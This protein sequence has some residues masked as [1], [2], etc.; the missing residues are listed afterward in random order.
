MKKRI[1]SLLLAVMMIACLLPA[2]VFAWPGGKDRY[3]HIDVRV[4][5]TLIID[6]KVN[7]VSQPGYPKN[8]KVTV[9]DVSATQ[10]GKDVGKF[11]KKT[12]QGEENEWR[13][14]GLNL[15]LDDTIVINCTISY[16]LNGKNHSQSF[17]KTYTG[18]ALKQA[19]QECPGKSG[20]DFNIEA[21]DVTEAI[22]A[23]VGFFTQAGGT[24]KKDGQNVASVLYSDLVVGSAFPAEPDKAAGTHYAFDGWYPADKNGNATSTVKVTTFPTVVPET[25]TYYVAKWKQ[26]SVDPTPIEPKVAVYKVEHYLEQSDGTY[27]VEETEFPLYGEIGATVSGTPKTTFEGYAYNAEKSAAT[28]SGKVVLP[29]EVSGSVEFLVLKLYYDISSVPIVPVEPKVAAYRVEHYLEQSD[30]NYVIDEASTQFP[31]YGEIGS[32][33]S[34]TPKTFEGYAYNSVKSADTASG[35]V[36]LPE[37]VSSNLEILVLKLYYDIAEETAE[38]RVEHYLQQSGD[39]YTLKDSEVLVGEVGETA[40]ATPKSYYG[41]TY[42]ASKSTASGVVIRPVV[43]TDGEGLVLKLYY[44]KRRPI[45]PDRETSSGASSGGKQEHDANP[46]TGENGLTSLS[47]LLAVLSV[48]GAATL[49]LSHKRKNEKG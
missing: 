21:T 48:S 11:S 24:L 25:D 37:M 3:D 33:V 31:L 42:N 44:D 20:F 45:L 7:G 16:Q 38:Y 5:G 4:A 43:E 6:S 13:K 1:L 10:N 22:T 12:G 49:V 29:Q 19:V 26:T 23:N 9:S 18:D 14:N 15:S 30:G 39:T 40:V 8:V 41:Y 46:N 17:S 47:I 27:K 35:V 32:T 36:I 34:A 2:T 28:A